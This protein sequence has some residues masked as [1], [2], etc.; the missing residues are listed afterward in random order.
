MVVLKADERKKVIFLGTPQLAVRVLQ[1][2]LACQRM[3]KLVLV[4]TQPP[5]RSSRGKKL[6][7]SPV[8]QFALEQGIPVV[9]PQ[10]A[11]DPD[12]LKILQN[13][14]PDLCLT[15]AYG[16]YLPQE[17]LA[18]PEYGTLNIHPSLLP[19]Y[20]GAAPVQRCLE[21]GDSLT[22]VSVL[23]SVA[24]MDAGPLLAQEEYPLN[25]DIQ[26]PELLEILF[27][28]GAQ[29]LIQKLPQVFARSVV[30][31]PQDPTCATWARKIL[32]QEA[33]LNFHC[34]AKVLHNKVRAFAGWPGAKAQFLYA[35]KPLEMKIIK[36]QLSPKND[37]GLAPLQLCFESHSLSICC[38]DAQVLK[39]LQLQL[40]GKKVISAQNFQNAHKENILKLEK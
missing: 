34:S 1:A 15:A 25:E 17:F 9:A 27:E 39:I 32:P 20:K 28:K 23:Y 22:G 6:V 7:P 40:P 8:H 10:S 3:L 30:P 18:L 11:K 38:G 16:Q 37:Q 26:A 19:R 21:N 4:V 35:G 24:Q 33:F 13:L 2:L 5:A 31:T 36:T 14:K 29:L 12:F